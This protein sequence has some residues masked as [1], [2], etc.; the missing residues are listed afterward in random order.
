MTWSRKQERLLSLLEEKRK[1]FI[2]NAVTRGVNPNVSLRDSGIAWL[3][4]VPARWDLRK[5]AWL[6][7]ERDQRGRSDLPLLEV[8]LNAGV[9]QRQFAREKIR[10]YG[11]RHQ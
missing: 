8:S 9:V 3:G 2:T 4:D 10:E 6:F 11:A 7:C 1:A 5:I